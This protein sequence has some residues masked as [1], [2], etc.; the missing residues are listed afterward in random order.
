M[1]VSDLILVLQQQDPD[2]S[3]WISVDG[4]SGL[5]ESIRTGEGF[6]EL[7]ED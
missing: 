6:V 2:A 4:I 5:I 1:S 7:K 3:V